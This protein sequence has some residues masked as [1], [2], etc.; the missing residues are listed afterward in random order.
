MPGEMGCDPLKPIKDKL[1]DIDKAIGNLSKAG[2]SNL[3]NEISAVRSD[4]SD[5]SRLLKGIVDGMETDEVRQQHRSETENNIIQSLTENITT[6]MSNI[7]NRIDGKKFHMTFP[8]DQVN[9]IKELCAVLSEDRVVSILNEIK[10]YI[11][12]QKTEAADEI[13]KAGNDVYGKVHQGVQNINNA[14]YDA[15][16]AV[17]NAAGFYKNKWAWLVCMMLLGVCLVVGGAAMMYKGYGKQKAAEQ[18]IRNAN[19]VVENM[20]DYRYWL[21]Y[22]ARNPKTA[23]RLQREMDNKYG[24]RIYKESIN[25]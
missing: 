13:K 14:R 9:S 15:V 17:Q 5:L 4:I 21:I 19:T 16:N 23:E 20:P 11:K 7:E 1:N 12:Q 3:E 2:S 10:E 8:L 18:A 24:K 22:K 25:P 6:Q